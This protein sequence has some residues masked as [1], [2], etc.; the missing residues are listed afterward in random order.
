MR[1]TILTIDGR[2]YDLLVNRKV[3][4][5]FEAARIVV[6]A[7]QPTSTAMEILRLCI[8]SIQCFTPEPHELWVIDN[9]S[10][11]ANVQ[12]LS[13]SENINVVLNRTEPLPAEAT[14]QET[15]TTEPESQSSWGSYA[16]A[17]G[18]EIAVRLIDS[19][20]RCLVS[21]HMDSMPC[22]AGWL[23]FLRSK[24]NNGVA[25]AG[26]RMDRTRNPEGV[27][28]VLG[29]AVDFQQFRRLGLDFFPDL[30]SADVGDRIT[31][32]LREAGF[33]VFG[34]ENTIWNESLVGQIHP[35]SRMRN[36]PADR[37]F[38]DAGNV[39]FLHLGRG[40]RRSSGTDL[41]G[42]GVKEWIDFAKDHL[43]SAGG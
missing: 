25:A 1:R 8:R 29:L 23:S 28:H 9:N 5:P 41:K 3:R 36:L 22:R 43:S 7:V 18:M 19:Q 11:T 33:R 17:I 31:A 32:E 24:M 12:W 26:V 20:S 21:L 13:E 34:C 39:I 16:N 4:R 42:R 35:D 40:V 27:L 6:V 14:A 37:S 38:D 2:D 10:P 30:P 15:R